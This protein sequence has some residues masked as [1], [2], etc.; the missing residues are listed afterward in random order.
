MGV[1]LTSADSVGP[2]YAKVVPKVTRGLQGWFTFD[3]DVS[4]FAL[5]RFRGKPNAV[6][7]GSP[8]A[9]PTHGRFKGGSNFLLT[10]IKDADE[11]T[12]YAVVRA[13]VAPT[14]NAD[15]VAP[16]SSYTGVSTVPEITGASGGSS[17]FL[18]ANSVV[19]A[20]MARSPNGVYELELLNLVS[21]SPTSWRL[22]VARSRTGDFSTIHDLTNNM[23]LVGKTITKRPVNDQFFRIGGATRDY[24]GESD[25]SAAAIY[26]AYH[27][28]QEIQAVA[29]SIRER[30]LRLGIVV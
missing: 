9:Y 15:G 30:M 24:T 20:G 7:V 14:S 5:N 1:T 28:E 2:W 3:T 19:S 10:P 17:I 22:L 25:I 27:S 13:V 6:V 4:R 21:G 29:S 11:V 8:V 16:V 23:S 26:T 12:L 18:R